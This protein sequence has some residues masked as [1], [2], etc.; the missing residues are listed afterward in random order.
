MTWWMRPGPSRFCA[1]RNPSPS[2]PQRVLD[3]N[4][5]V[6]VPHFAVGRPAAPA[7]SHRRDRPNHL[8]PGRVRG[9]DDLRGAAMRL[10]LWIGDRHHDPEGRPLGAR[11][12][13]LVAVDDP[14][15]T[16][17]HRPRPE[18]RRVRPGHVRLGHREE[19]A[20]LPGD[21]RP[22]P[23]LLLLLRPELPED[24]SVSR[25]RG[26]AAEQQL[27]PERAPDLLVQERVC[28]E[29][30]VRA[31]G[32]RRQVRGPKT[33]VLRDPACALHERV[34]VLVLA[35]EGGLVRIHVRLHEGPYARSELL[36]LVSRTEIGDRHGVSIALMPHIY[37]AFLVNTD[38]GREAAGFRGLRNGTTRGFVA[39]RC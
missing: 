5:D 24:L 7:V 25:I 2:C 22:E 3:R 12:E 29:A 21:Q 20:D 28:E 18:P 23:A 14:L 37:H 4:P 38:P 35:V 1:I 19:R 26:L 9:Y 8:H 33:F 15:V 39:P 6:R 34:G 10:G 36:H 16:V 17:P 13:P 31:A 32:F 11:R 27:T 30:P